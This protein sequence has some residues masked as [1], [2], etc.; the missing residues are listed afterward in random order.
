MNA[1]AM[2]PYR[3]ITKFEVLSAIS[4]YYPAIPIILLLLSTVNL[5]WHLKAVLH[6]GNTATCCIQLVYLSTRTV[7]YNF[8]NLLIVRLWMPH[9][10]SCWG[11]GIALSLFNN[12]ACHMLPPV[13][14]VELHLAFSIMLHA[15]C[16]LLL[17]Q[18]NR[19]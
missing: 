19:T 3:R 7:S 1:L 12:V 15:T 6:W 4:L 11:S 10:A 14:A 9:V 13:E 2:H 18:W 16:C 5:G 8:Q 17:S